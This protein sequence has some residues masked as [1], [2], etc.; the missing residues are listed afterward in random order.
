MI[1][2]YVL[3][4]LLVFLLGGHPSYEWP[5]K[6]TGWDMPTVKLLMRILPFSFAVI[7]RVRILSAFI[8]LRAI[9]TAGELARVDAARAGTDHFAR[10]GWFDW[11]ALRNPTRTLFP[12]A[13]SLAREHQ[14]HHGAL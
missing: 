9:V 10:C 8:G 5:H 1:M 4:A 6:C 11:G 3:V 7:R 13:R 14:H 12:R 2:N